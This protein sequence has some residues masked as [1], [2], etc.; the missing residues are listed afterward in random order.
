MLEKSLKSD[1]LAPRRGVL[2]CPVGTSWGR[3]GA[4]WGHVGGSWGPLGAVL[5]PKLPILV[6][7]LEFC[8]F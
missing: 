8:E 4:S 2:D 3:L 7:F 5:R 1:A 6:I